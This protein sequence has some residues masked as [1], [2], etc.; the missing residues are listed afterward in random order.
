MLA[1]SRAGARTGKRQP[2]RLGLCQLVRQP[3][4]CSAR[5]GRS[6]VV[7]EHH[8]VGVPKPL[9]L[10]ECINDSHA[11]VHAY[12][13][14]NGEPGS[15]HLEEPH[16]DVYAEP[17]CVQDADLVHHPQPDRDA[18]S[19]GYAHSQPGRHAVPDAER[20]PDCDRVAGCH[21]LSVDY[22]IIHG[23]AEREPDSKPYGDR[24]ADAEREPVAER[25]TNRHADTKHD[26]HAVKYGDRIADDV[27]F[28]DADAERVP[29]AEPERIANVNCIA[30]ADPERVPHDDHD[31]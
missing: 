1:R 25:V 31:A 29:V 24:D 15:Q 3:D 13:H 14:A 11:V 17:E 5:R 6:V 27:S 9:N 8:R 18:E 10:V 2:K 26:C 12:A 16:P 19:L 23:H 28:D 20:Q 21:A 4:P 22:R 7:R 30:D